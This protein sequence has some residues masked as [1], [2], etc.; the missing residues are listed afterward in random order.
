M[1]V[2]ERV[3]KKLQRRKLCEAHTNY[4]YWSILE[5]STLWHPEI[6]LINNHLIY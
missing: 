2:L 4:Y 6:F 1:H 3:T 5:Q